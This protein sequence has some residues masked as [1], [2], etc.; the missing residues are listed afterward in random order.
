MD[1]WH[2]ALCFRLA[3][4]KKPSSHQEANSCCSSLAA[5]EKQDDLLSIRFQDNSEEGILTIGRKF[6]KLGKLLLTES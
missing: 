5:T 3:E 6:F 2:G 4:K 1:T